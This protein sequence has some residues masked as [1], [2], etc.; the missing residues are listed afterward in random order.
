[1]A[2]SILDILRQHPRERILVHPLDWTSRQYNLL[3][4]E[5]RDCSS[6][7]PRSP[8]AACTGPICSNGQKEGN[9]TEEEGPARRLAH[10]PTFQVKQIAI[11]ALL[12]YPSNCVKSAGYVCYILVQTAPLK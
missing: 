7:H 5:I 6:R 3:A 2:A 11:N 9:E 12:S 1:M 8:A 10:A 4:C